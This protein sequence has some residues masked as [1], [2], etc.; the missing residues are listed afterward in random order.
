[1]ADEMDTSSA[2]SDMLDD[3]ALRNIREVAAK[4]P[5]GAPGD[6]DMCGEWSG[7]LVGGCCA[8]CR[9]RYGFP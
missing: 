3:V 6:C 5:D 2:T 9:D 7:R 4:I 1:M 8:P